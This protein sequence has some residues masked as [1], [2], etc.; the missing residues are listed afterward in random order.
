MANNLSLIVG[1]GF[2]QA[3]YQPVLKNLGMQVIT[4]DPVK[5][6]DFK[7]VEDAIA[8][9]G[10]FL[11]VNICTPNFTHEDIARQVAPHAD[12]VFVEKPGVKNAAAWLKLVTDFPA[13]RFMM[14]KNNQYRD[15]I[16]LMKSLAYDSSLVVIKWASK[17]RIPNP[18]SW[19]TTKELAFGGVS[20]D[21]MPHMLSYYTALENYLNGK[22]I[23]CYSEQ[24]HQLKDITST[25]Y[26]VVNH[27]GIHDVDDFCNIVFDQRGIRWV[28]IA[29]WKNNEEDDSSITFYIDGDAHRIELGL[30][31]EEAYQKMIGTA[32]ANLNNDS[33]WDSQLS[34][35]LWIH[36]QLDRL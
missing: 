20:R 24:R 31:P 23:E 33:F 14:V 12:I 17:N 6:A 32:I 21:L 3:V 9:H 34:Q 1:M 19:F 10:H 28:L 25:D 22:E 5:S 27:N 29:D 2:G 16:G 15:N 4:V 36:N 26:G 18:G 30:C 7:T 8:A 13:T 11:T 35:D